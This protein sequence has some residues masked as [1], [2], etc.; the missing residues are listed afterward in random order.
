MKEAVSVGPISILVMGAHSNVA[1]FLMSNPEL[2]KNVEHIYA[3]GGAVESNNNNSAEIEIGN[4]FPQ[5]SNPFAEFNFFV[6]PFAAY[7]VP[8]SHYIILYYIYIEK[9]LS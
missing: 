7:T 9:L 5:H 6:D 1:I 8:L 2:K 4:L 3:M